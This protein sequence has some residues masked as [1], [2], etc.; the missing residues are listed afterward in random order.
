MWHGESPPGAQGAA[1]E[2]GSG[3]NVWRRRFSPNALYPTVAASA[4]G[5]A[6]A[7][8]EDGKLVAAPLVRT[9]FNRPAKLGR[10][11]ASQPVIALAPAAERGQYLAAWLD[12]EATLPEPF[13]ARLRCP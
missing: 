3:R 1:F 4:N 6:A 10:A 9:G 7:W 13:V 8:I 2:A 11:S 5:A 12:M